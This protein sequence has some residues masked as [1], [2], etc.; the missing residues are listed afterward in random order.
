M[1][2][3]LDIIKN[4]LESLSTPVQIIPEYIEILFKVHKLLETETEFSSK[5]FKVISVV[6]IILLFK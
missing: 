6:I 1:F 4:S 5:L 3:F 2:S